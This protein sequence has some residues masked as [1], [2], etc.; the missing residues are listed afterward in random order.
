MDSICLVPIVTIE[1]SGGLVREVYDEHGDLV[2]YRVV[3]H[4]SWE[5]GEC[6]FCRSENT[7]NM[8]GKLEKAIGLSR[9]R[10]VGFIPCF[11]PPMVVERYRWNNGINIKVV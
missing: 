6:P 7:A 3:D 11:M 1:L 5:G 10:R 4:D 8:G 9:L 2:S